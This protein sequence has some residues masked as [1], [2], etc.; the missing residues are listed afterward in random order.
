LLRNVEAVKLILHF[1]G[2]EAF[3]CYFWKLDLL[4]MLDFCV[5]PFLLSTSFLFFDEFNWNDFGDGF[6]DEFQEQ[7]WIDDEFVVD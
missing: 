3:A 5:E 4:L 2:F 1:N 6:D 7:R